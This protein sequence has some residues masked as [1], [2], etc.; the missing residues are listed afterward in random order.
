MIT[1]L[2]GDATQ[3]RAD[4]PKIVAHVCND[5][6]AWGAGFTRAVTRRWLE[7]ETAYRVWYRDGKHPLVY[8]KSYVEDVL[9]AETF[10]L[11]RVQIIPVG[12]L[13][14][15]A[16]ML[17]QRGLGAQRMPLR[18][19]ALFFCLLYVATVAAK[20]EASVHM[21]RIGCGLAGG[22]WDRVEPIIE[23][24]F[25]GLFAKQRVYVYDLESRK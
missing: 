10:E 4:G 13:T 14:Y 25:S 12:N 7:P 1:Y 5:V 3:P 2:K 9:T 24:A 8:P 19:E 20:L 6:G 16:N 22:T 11:G 18:Y 15:V 23:E 21:P 17:A